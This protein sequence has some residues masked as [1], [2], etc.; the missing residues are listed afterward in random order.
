VSTLTIPTTLAKIDCGQCGGVYAITERHRSW[1]EEHGKCWTCPYCKTGWGF[2]ETE[3]D[4]LRKRLEREQALRAS[5]EGQAQR[6]HQ[7]A[8]AERARA[9]GYKGAMTKAKKRVANGVC[10]CCQRTFQ[11]LARHMETKH[12]DFAETPCE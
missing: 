11:N 3:N 7:Q 2:S 8:E 9:N 10:P 4:R 6:A 12:P 1:C 5:A